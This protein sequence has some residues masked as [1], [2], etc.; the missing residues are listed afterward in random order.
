MALP[1]KR[2]V[3]THSN[4]EHEFS[5]LYIS[6][7]DNQ[8]GYGVNNLKRFQFLG[9]G[10]SKLLWP[11]HVREYVAECRPDPALTREEYP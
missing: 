9:Y 8:R 7:L 2:L 3:E 1:W 5:R 10:K 4:L 11:L 6:A